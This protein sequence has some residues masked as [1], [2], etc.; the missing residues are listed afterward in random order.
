MKTLTI[1][2]PTWNR[3]IFLNENLKILFSYIERGLI[4]KILVCNNGS[5][6]NTID[7]LIPFIYSK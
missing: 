6:D 5:T 2:I 3:A 7:V 1:I 4:F